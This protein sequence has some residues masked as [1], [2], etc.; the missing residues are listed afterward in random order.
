[1]QGDGDIPTFPP[2]CAAKVI[3]DE[4]C[5]MFGLTIPCHKAFSE[6]T[7]ETFGFGLV[8]SHI[9]TFVV[10][11][12]IGVVSL[13]NIKGRWEFR[14][15]SLKTTCALYAIETSFFALIR[16]YW[17]VCKPLVA[18]A[19]L[20]NLFEWS[21]VLHV[22]QETSNLNVLR[23]RL[24]IA[25]LFINIQIIVC[26]C[27]PDLETSLGLEMMFG[28]MMDFG[29]PLMFLSQFSDPHRRK[30][31]GFAAVAHCIHLLGTIL[32]LVF[33]IH[34]SGHASW[35]ASFFLE[36]LINVT[37]PLSHFLYCFWS[38][39]IDYVADET[40]I[41]ISWASEKDDVFDERCN[42]SEKSVFPLEK[43]QTVVEKTWTTQPSGSVTIESSKE[44]DIIQKILADAAL[45]KE[46]CK[47]EMANERRI[48]DFW[49]YLITG[50][51]LGLVPLLVFP[52]LLMS[53]CEGSD[54]CII[55]SYVTKTSVAK[56]ERQGQRN[57][58]NRSLS[59][60]AIEVILK[61]QNPGLIDVRV[62]N[63]DGPDS[64]HCVETWKDLTSMTEASLSVSNVM[65]GRNVKAIDWYTE[66]QA[67]TCRGKENGVVK[68][69]TD[70][71]C[72]PLLKIFEPGDNSY[73]WIPGANT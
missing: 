45:C 8:A 66:V 24:S 62:L 71:L 55:R 53:E 68:M 3:D 27:I 2:F 69:K 63:G 43:L 14:R 4:E 57:F 58:L 70:T 16:L 5:S 36:I 29:I 22:A 23:K 59:R 51:V 67:T 18:F 10:T 44:K 33:A 56:T 39:Q 61:S 28:L 15:H 13:W 40:K 20:H 35:F 60:D 11:L 9:W 49:K 21:I 42:G 38:Y 41:T 32:P 1:M 7:L 30:I 52:R 46:P 6:D 26:L 31:Y 64:Y 37:V 25:A 72:S 34:F 73:S 65:T 12:V 48:R 47:C 17:G 19:A 54:G 50:F